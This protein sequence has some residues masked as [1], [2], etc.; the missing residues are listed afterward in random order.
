M[1][2]LV[3]SFNYKDL[4][5]LT[6]KTANTLYKARDRAELNPEDLEDTLVW[7]ARHA[8]P[9]LKR[10]MLEYALAPDELPETP[11]RH[12]ARRNTKAK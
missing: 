7:L 10:R 3:F 4:E 8:R 1:K 2:P 6:G 5:R 12:G 9:D 11:G